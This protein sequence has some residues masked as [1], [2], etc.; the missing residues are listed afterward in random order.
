[1]ERQNAGTTAPTHLAIYHV[2][3]GNIHHFKIRL[4][5][6]TR[7]SDTHFYNTIS[8]RVTARIHVE[9]IPKAFQDALRSWLQRHEPMVWEEDAS[10]EN[11]RILGAISYKVEDGTAKTLFKFAKSFS[12]DRHAEPM[13][14]ATPRWG[15]HIEAACL[16]HLQKHDVTHVTTGDSPTDS[17]K[18]V[19]KEAGLAPWKRIP[20]AE[21]IEKLEGYY[22]EKARSRK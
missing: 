2:Q 7:F 17:V 4:G 13:R 10:D 1:M 11:H 16:R 15:S 19:L 21:W 5:R 9:A 22:R 8:N 12:S 6:R 20:I 3:E 18:H 14:A